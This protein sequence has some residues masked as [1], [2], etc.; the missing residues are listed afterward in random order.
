V[1]SQEEWD[2]LCLFIEEAWPYPFDDT[3]AKAWRVL[4]DDYDAAQVFAAVKACMMRRM[5]ERPAV[6][7]L[8]AEIRRDSSKPTFAEACTLIFGRGG[9][10]K[11][12]TQVHKGSWEA[13]ERDR[14][15]EEAAWQRAD[16]LHPLIGTFIVAQ[17]LHRL[18]RLDLD[19]PEYGGA[20]RKQL[21]SDWEEHV[22]VNETRDIAALIA[23]RERGQL[24]AGRERG[25][26][27]LSRFDPLRALTRGPQAEVA[28]LIR[29]AS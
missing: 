8:V 15:D 14:L 16:E 11:A 20:R 27:G 13:G 7:A 24:G 9:V 4:L 28:E 23:G 22:E 3:T 2:S 21:A 19:D 25:E 18:K 12:R 5:L 26:L 1:I 6:S 10:I 17:G 29:V